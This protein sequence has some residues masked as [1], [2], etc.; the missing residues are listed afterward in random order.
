MRLVNKP[1]TA[2]KSNV[3]KQKFNYKAMKY[4]SAIHHK[5]NEKAIAILKQTFNQRKPSSPYPLAASKVFFRKFRNL[6]GQRVEVTIRW[7]YPGR[8]DKKNNCV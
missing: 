6:I 1:F 3:R 5:E 4:V 7:I 2:I 8:Q